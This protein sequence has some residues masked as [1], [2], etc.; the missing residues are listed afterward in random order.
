MFFFQPGLSKKPDATSSFKP[1]ET[2]YFWVNLFWNILFRQIYYNL[3]WNF[4]VSWT[5]INQNTDRI[6]DSLKYCSRSCLW[7]NYEWLDGRPFRR[8]TRFWYHTWK[9]QKKRY[10]RSTTFR[11]WNIEAVHPNRRCK[12]LVQAQYIWNLN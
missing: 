9:H 1:S 7:W 11:L 3:I 10:R 6:N 12:R 8:W 2:F 4:T 5:I